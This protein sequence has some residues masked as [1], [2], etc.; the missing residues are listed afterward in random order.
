VDIVRTHR[1][2]AGLRF[3]APTLGVA[4]LLG[5]ASFALPALMHGG[6]VVPIIA[7]SSVVFDSARIGT[8]VRSVRAAGTLVPDRVH[9][10]ATT[11]EGLVTDIGIRAGSRVAAGTVVAVLRNPDLD[12]AV[13]DAR[14]QLG[15]A[16]AELR[17]AREE[18]NAAR[19]DRAGAY[20]SALAEAERASEESR[21]DASLIRDGLIGTLQYRQATSK[22][23]ETRALAEIAARKIG[24]DAALEDAKVAAAQAVVDRVAAT[25]A[26]DRAHVDTLVVRAGSSGVAQS[27]TAD[28][29]QRLTL[30]AELARI[31]E[32]RDLKAVLQVAE[33]DMRGVAPGMRV[34]LDTNGSGTLAGHVARVAPVAVNGS[35]AVDVALDRVRPGIRSAQNVDGTIELLRLHRALTIARPA[36]AADGTTIDLFCLAP[37]G[38]RALRTRVRLGMGALDRVEVVSGLAAGST[39]IVSDTSAFDHAA[40]LRLASL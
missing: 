16:R 27:V 1:R 34:A 6:P 39:V 40:E 13:E 36:G 20:R 14:A 18:A 31:A 24:V 22:A 17:S 33:G 7:R 9:V 11:A 30:G 2:P 29:G 23:N 37:G 32:E 10:V 26:A 5:G 4:A 19:L 28:T 15:A 21:T 38:T 3:L 8:L 12:A 35:V 25:L